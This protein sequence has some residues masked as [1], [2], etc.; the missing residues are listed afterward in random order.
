MKTLKKQWLEVVGAYQFVLTFLFMGERSGRGMGAGG[1]QREKG[2]GQAPLIWVPK[3]KK[4]GRGPTW[5]WE[6]AGGYD[7]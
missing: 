2:M 7:P 1:P 6:G 5:G 3:S 4:T